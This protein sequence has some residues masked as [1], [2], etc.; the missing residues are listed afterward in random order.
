MY[1][2]ETKHLLYSVCFR[3]MAEWQNKNVLTFRDASHCSFYFLKILSVD[4]KMSVGRFLKDLSVNGKFKSSND[5]QTP[6]PKSWFDVHDGRNGHDGHLIWCLHKLTKHSHE[7]LS[8][9]QKKHLYILTLTKLN[10]ST[11]SHSNFILDSALER[12]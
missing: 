9:L 8:R 5:G 11:V 3:H 1:I 10:N 6:V 7:K 4:S 2:Y 12:A